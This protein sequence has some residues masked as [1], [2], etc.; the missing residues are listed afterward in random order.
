MWTRP[1]QPE[2]G[3]QTSNPIRERAV[4]VAV[5]VTLQNV[6]SA[7]TAGP[8]VGLK[9]PLAISA[10]ST[11]PFVSEA[12]VEAAR[13]RRAQQRAERSTE[14]LLDRGRYYGREL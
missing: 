7:F 4:G 9:S 12:D 1:F 8:S 11:R 10:R 2:S 5:P 13:A 14:R 3:S 6:G